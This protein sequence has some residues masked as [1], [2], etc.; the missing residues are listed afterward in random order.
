MAK[1]WQTS[2]GGRALGWAGGGPDLLLHHVWVSV[3]VVG[4]AFEWR[5]K[6]RRNARGDP[7]RKGG[8]VL[9]RGM[10][11]GPAKPVF[12]YISGPMPPFVGTSKCKSPQV[13]PPPPGDMTCGAA[14]VTPRG[15]VGPGRQ[16]GP[17]CYV[18]PA[19]P[20]N[21]QDCHT[22]EHRPLCTGVGGGCSAKSLS[23]CA[24]GTQHPVGHHW[25]P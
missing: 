24:Q 1:A 17:E 11:G 6:P 4:W 22:H 14:S 23:A 8:M 13:P 10:G 20:P 19:R 5:G 25:G 16:C 21:P 12:Q 9:D 7:L 18:S 15:P 2:A 3:G